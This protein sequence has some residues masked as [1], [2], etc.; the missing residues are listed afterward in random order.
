MLCKVFEGW[1]R[2]QKMSYQSQR[3]EGNS[4]ESEAT[5]YSTNNKIRVLIESSY[6]IRDSHQLWNVSKVY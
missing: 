1:K 3:Y 2:S 6:S 5:I 4:T